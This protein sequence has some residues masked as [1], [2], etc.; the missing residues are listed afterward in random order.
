MVVW[1]VVNWRVAEASGMVSVQADCSCSEAV[2]MMRERARV[3]HRSLEE[4]AD[5]VGGIA[6]CSAL[7]GAGS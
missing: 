7:E 3:E 4:V 5:A 6:C 2:G 1:E